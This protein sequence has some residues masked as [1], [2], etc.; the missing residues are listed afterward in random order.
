MN[1][2]LEVIND[3]IIECR[4][5]GKTIK[6][7]TSKYEIKVYQSRPQPRYAKAVIRIEIQDLEIADY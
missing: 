7:S 2:L 3:M 4:N 6:H 5:T 1:E